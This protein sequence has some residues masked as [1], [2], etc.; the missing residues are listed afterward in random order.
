MFRKKTSIKKLIFLFSLIFTGILTPSFSYGQTDICPGLSDQLAAGE[1]A[2]AEA[3]ARACLEK[4]P[5]NVPL[6]VALSKSLAGQQEYDEAIS[7]AEQALEKYPKDADLLAW[8]ARVLAWNGD[9]NRAWDLVLK[10]PRDALDDKDNARLVADIAFWKK[11]YKQG[12]SRYNYFLEKWPRDPSALKNRGLCFW[13]TGND[14]KA[15]EDFIS[16]CQLSKSDNNASCDP[17]KFFKESQARFHMVFQP[18]YWTRDKEITN[19]NISEDYHGFDG[20]FLFDYRP[21]RTLHIGA[22]TDHRTRDYGDGQLDDQYLEGYGTYLWEK[23]FYLYGAA[24]ATVDPDFS[25]LWTGT[26]EPGWIFKFGLEVY[27]RYWR[28]QFE[29]SGVHV[30]SPALVYT[31]GPAQLYFRYY[32]GIDDDPEIDQSNAYIGKLTFFIKSFSLSGGGG[33]GDHTDYLEIDNMERDE[34][35]LIMAGVGW[36]IHWRHGV[37]LDYIYRNEIAESLALEVHYTQ[38]QYLLGYKVRF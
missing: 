12:V 37:M 21:W 27:L 6:K 32:H 19:K 7:L 3:T 5:E 14:D 28:I 18:E 30:I 24:G 34:Y 35:W 29:E 25:P 11:D 8:L 33:Y 13:K 16:L 22:S 31:L 26:I 17:L 10:L 23:G 20:F 4:T 36:Q 15:K 1:F 2:K 38:H 9:F